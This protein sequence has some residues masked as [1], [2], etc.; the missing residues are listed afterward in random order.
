M[1][2]FSLP[3]SLFN[4][5]RSLYRAK[6]LDTRRETIQILRYQSKK[7]AIMAP[8]KRFSLFYRP[9]AVKSFL[10]I[11]VVGVVVIWTI[12]NYIDIIRHL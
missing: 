1:S 11:T 5:L 7:P 9:Q 12:K 8:Q 10:F 2:F 6:T 4:I 3:L